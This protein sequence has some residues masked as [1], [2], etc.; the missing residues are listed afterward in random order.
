MKSSPFIL[1][2]L[3]LL[4]FANASAQITL[5]QIVGDNMVLQ[6]DQQIR[7]WGWA[8]ANEEI[9]LKFEGKKYKTTA[10]NA[11]NWEISLPPRQPGV[12]MT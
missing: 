9:S 6:R 8:S 3:S 2:I 1:L 10:D 11:G 5:P 12:L 7:I 4:F